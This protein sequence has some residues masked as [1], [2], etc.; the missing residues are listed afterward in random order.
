MK[1][2][3]NGDDE[4]DV[5]RTEENEGKDEDEDKRDDED[6]EDEKVNGEENNSKQESEAE[7]VVQW[8]CCGCNELREADLAVEREGQG[9]E[10]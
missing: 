6:E 9:Q 3:K 8:S 10:E 2:N 4:E 1:Q 5:A 7:S